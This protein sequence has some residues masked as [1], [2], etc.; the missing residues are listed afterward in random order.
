MIKNDIGLNAGTIW[1]LLSI[2]EELS[3]RQIGEMTSYDG[4]MIT[5][6]L[7]WLAREG[8]IRFSNKND[9]LFV[10]LNHSAT[11]MYY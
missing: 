10:G 11:D 9:V 8:K 3:I 7:G 4:V 5:L 6:A 2:N 1:H